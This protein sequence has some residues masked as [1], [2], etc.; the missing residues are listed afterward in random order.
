MRNDR[1]EA[2]GV[3]DDWTLISHHNHLALGNILCA[4]TNF[5]KRPAF[6]RLPIPRLTYRG[7]DMV[8]TVERVYAQVRHFRPRLQ[9]H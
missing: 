1:Q 8:Q 2:A 6:V 4:L 9:R 5:E 3:N 7:E